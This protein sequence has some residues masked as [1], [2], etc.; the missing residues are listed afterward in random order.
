MLKQ[1]EVSPHHHIVVCLISQIRRMLGQYQ[2][3]STYHLPS[4]PILTV[5]IPNLPVS[6]AEKALESLSSPPPFG[7]E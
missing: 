7:G 2:P 4:A 5:P 6:V 1:E 3:L